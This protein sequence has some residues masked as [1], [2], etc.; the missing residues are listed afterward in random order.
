[1]TPAAT[2]HTVA[3]FLISWIVIIAVLTAASLRLPSA[4]TAIFVL[5][6]LALILDLVATVNGSPGL[7]KAAG[8][9]VFAFAAAGAYLFAGSLSVA[10]GG[11][12]FPLGCPVMT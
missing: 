12:P 4:F 1:M 8:I 2:V 6:E 3:A 11:R 10:T 7:D 5:V 9:V